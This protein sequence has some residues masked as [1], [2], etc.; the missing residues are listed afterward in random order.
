MKK[1]F[2]LLAQRKDSSQH[3]TN[4]IAHQRLTAVNNFVTCCYTRFNFYHS[5]PWFYNPILPSW[6]WCCCSRRALDDFPRNL[7][8]T[9][10]SAHFDISRSCSVSFRL[11]VCLCARLSWQKYD[12]KLTFYDCENHQRTTTVPVYWSKC[13]KYD[14]LFEMDMVSFYGWIWSVYLLCFECLSGSSGRENFSSR[15]PP[16]NFLLIQF[17][18]FNIV[19]LPP[20]QL[21]TTI[22][23][24]A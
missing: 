22:R 1:F 6:C 15:V 4:V 21:E 19:A 18:R 23:M 13:Q 14:I 10:F 11:A 3:I 9:R 7:T 12:S 5:T 17:A 20:L 8:E 2:R 16:Q 24:C